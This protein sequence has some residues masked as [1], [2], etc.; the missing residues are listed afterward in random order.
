SRTVL[1]TSDQAGAAAACFEDNPIIIN[2]RDSGIF[3]GAGAPEPYSCRTRPPAHAHNGR[4]LISDFSLE[5]R[6]GS[7]EGLRPSSQRT[8]HG[9]ALH[10]E[11]P[12]SRPKC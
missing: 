1:Q 11:R 7:T 10:R 4:L 9:G 5:T 2:P 6:I 8:C 3:T 12:Q